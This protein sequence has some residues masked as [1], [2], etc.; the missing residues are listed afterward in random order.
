M[1]ITINITDP[2]HLAGI[3]AAY[4]ATIPSDPEQEPP[5]TD[6]QHYAQ[7]TMEQAAESWRGMFGP[8]RVL[9]SEFLLRCTSAEFAGITAAA[10]SDQIVAGLLARIRSEQYVWL[11]SEEVQQGLGYLVHAGLLT[12]ER[13]AEVLAY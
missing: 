3:Q 8:D 1:S 10:Q 9:S 12:P 11:A 4:A 5:Y 2:R 7:A 6:A 13:A